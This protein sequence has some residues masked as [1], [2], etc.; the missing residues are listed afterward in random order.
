M[1][2]AVIGIGVGILFVA[3]IVANQLWRRRARRRGLELP[4]WSRR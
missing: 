2:P 1:M 3:G 4:P